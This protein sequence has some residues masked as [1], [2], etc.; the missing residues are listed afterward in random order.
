MEAEVTPP[1]NGKALKFRGAVDACRPA[2][3]G[4]TSVAKIRLRH[5]LTFRQFAD[6]TM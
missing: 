5:R 6:L 1:G 2:R 3:D 4:K